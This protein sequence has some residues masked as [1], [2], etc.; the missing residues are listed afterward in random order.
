MR[1]AELGSMSKG[2]G[3]S[4]SPSPWELCTVTQMEEVKLLVQ[5]LPIWWTNLMFSAVFAQVGTLFLN[6]GT[7]MDRHMGPNFE[8]PVASIPLFITATT[9][10]FLPL[11]DKYFMPFVRGSTGDIRG[12]TLL[13]RIG[14]GRSSPAYP[15]TVCPTSHCLRGL[16]GLLNAL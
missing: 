8:I 5:M 10:I 7:T 4:S 16:S 13:Q 14:V 3:S 9:C 12:L 15:Y 11:Y 2:E 1:P 6:Q